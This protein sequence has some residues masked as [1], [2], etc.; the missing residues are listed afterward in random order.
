MTPH[1]SRLAQG[2]PMT[3]ISP[4]DVAVIAEM[5]KGYLTFV[6]LAYR[7]SAQRETYLQYVESLR[8][9]L[10]GRHLENTPLPL[11]SEDIE[12]IE[13][14]M[15]TF[16]VITAQMAPPTGERDATIHA[17]ACLR[18]RIALMRSGTASR[19]SLN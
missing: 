13:A 16:E 9:R 17:C 5:V 19:R 15:G 3:P 8:G 1:Q 10:A 12:T 6:R 4:G 11:T 18:Q 14:A 2:V 7:P